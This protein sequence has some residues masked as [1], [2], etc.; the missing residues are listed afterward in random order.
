M[1][2]WGLIGAIL[3]AIGAKAQPVGLLQQ[4]EV[5]RTPAEALPLLEWLER[6]LSEGELFGEETRIARL[7]ARFWQDPAALRRWWNAC[8]TSTA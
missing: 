3:L 5:A 6:A 4:L 1:V 8:S 7:T 2:R